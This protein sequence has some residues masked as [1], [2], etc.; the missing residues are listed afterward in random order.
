MHLQD[1]FFIFKKRSGSKFEIYAKKLPSDPNV[2]FFVTAAMF[3]DGSKIPTFIIYSMQGTP[4]N[5]HTKF[6]S[7]WPRS[8]RGEEF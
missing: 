2:L 5:I 1:V 4:R 6:G 7:N 3:F 8:V